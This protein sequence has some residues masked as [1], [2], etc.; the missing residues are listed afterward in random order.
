[1]FLKVTVSAKL[2]K[3]VNNV[4]TYTHYIFNNKLT[5]NDNILIVSHQVVCNEILK[6]CTR[7]MKGIH[8][9]SLFNYPRGGLTHVFDKDEWLFEPI[10][11]E[12]P[13]FDN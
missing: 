11:W 2:T 4:I 10:N 6:I 8:I 7:K 1:M 5:R 12:R 3:I 9:T 13:E